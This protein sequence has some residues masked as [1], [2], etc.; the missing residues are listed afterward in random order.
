MR[1]SCKTKVNYKL[2]KK[3]IYK[4]GDIG[5]VYRMNGEEILSEGK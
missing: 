3:Y 5:R 2:K 1:L 4:T